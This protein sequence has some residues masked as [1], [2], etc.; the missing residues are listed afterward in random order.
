MEGG[1]RIWRGGGRRKPGRP[2]FDEPAGDAWLPR[3]TLRPRLVLGGANR[4]P[5]IRR[6]AIEPRLEQL[7]AMDSLLTL[8]LAESKRPHVEG[9]SRL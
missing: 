7:L 9:G 1:S 8:L 4:R 5:Q 3:F 6:A 2:A